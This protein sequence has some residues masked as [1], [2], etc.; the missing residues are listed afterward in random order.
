MGHAVT[1]A[2][3][4]LRADP[5]PDRPRLPLARRSTRCPRSPGVDGAPR[6]PARPPIR[7]GPLCAEVIKTTSD[8]YVGQVS[9]RPGVLRHA[10]PR[11]GGARVRP[12][13]WPSAGHEDHDVDERIGAPHRD[14]RQPAHR[15]RPAVAG[16]IVAVSKLTQR[17]D[18]RHPLLARRPAAHGAVAHA[19]AA[20]ARRDHR[21]TAQA[22]RTSSAPPWPASRPRTRRC[23]SSTPRRPARSCCGRLGEAHADLMLDRL[24]TRYGVEVDAS[25]CA[26]RCARRSPGPP[27][28]R[29]GWSS[30]PAAT[31]S[32]RSATSR[33]SRC[34]AGSGLR[35]R[36]QDRRRRRPAQFIPSVE[37]G[38]R[39]QIDAGRGRRL[40][41]RR[42]P[43]DPRRRQVRTR[44]DSSDMAFQTA[45]GLALKDAA[46]KTHDQPAR[47]DGHRDRRRPRRVRR[48]RDHRR[49][50]PARPDQRAPTPLHRRPVA[51]GGRR[52][53]GGDLPLRHRHPQH[54]PRHRRLHP[55]VG[56]LRAAAGERWP[57]S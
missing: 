12:L 3:V 47:A 31:A 6:R 48:R 52:A 37:K 50:H 13:R 43:G 38:V 39:H 4:G 17:R 57:R 34:R 44:V 46:A 45:G 32:T 56:R 30:S 28:A 10:A 33:S 1:A 53:R 36:G 8:P 18:R 24:R 14:A 19:D 2:N 40:P 7:D 49:V 16:S 42:H 54:H 29:A 9:H 23:A 35:V 21:R 55:G 15:L 20:A 22:T 51:G 26:R 41:R 5:R 11:R 25:R 27:R